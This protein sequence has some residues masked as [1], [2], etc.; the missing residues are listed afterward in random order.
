MLCRPTD[1]AVIAS[2]HPVSVGPGAPSAHH[3]LVVE[4]NISKEVVPDMSKNTMP[5]IAKDRDYV[6]VCGSPVWKALVR[7]G[8]FVRGGI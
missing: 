7:R 8:L 3:V 1:V 2:G 6:L 4:T 5:D